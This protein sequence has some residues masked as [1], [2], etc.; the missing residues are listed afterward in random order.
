MGMMST[1]LVSGLSYLDLD[2]D[3]KNDL[4]DPGK[5]GVVSFFLGGF[6]ALGARGAFL[7]CTGRC[8]RKTGPPQD[9]RTSAEYQE[10]LDTPEFDARQVMDST[11]AQA[12][13]VGAQPVQTIEESHLANQV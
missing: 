7:A 2:N 9:R 13:V 12:G 5:L 3:A 10:E 1:L 11:Q 4:K 6:V 8:R